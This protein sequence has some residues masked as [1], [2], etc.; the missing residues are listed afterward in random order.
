MPADNPPR[1]L[2][3]GD[4]LPDDF[5]TRPGDTLTFGAG[6]YIRAFN[7]EG[8]ASS[9]TGPTASSTAGT[10]PPDSTRQ[11]GCWPSDPGDAA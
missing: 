8:S 1:Y 11:Q 5:G 3:Q 6:S 7:A 10:R 9:P 2:R 4:E